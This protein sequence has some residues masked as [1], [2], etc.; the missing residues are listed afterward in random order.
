MAGF[1]G[2]EGGYGSSACECAG[3]TCACNVSG[4]WQFH[5]LTHGISEF[6]DRASREEARLDWKPERGFYS[7][8]LS[9]YSLVGPIKPR[10]GWL[11]SCT[12]LCSEIAAVL[13]KQAT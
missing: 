2:T 6:S 9:G 13:V 1:P 8:E 7:G 3:K 5:D 12:G 4:A 11:S 10:T